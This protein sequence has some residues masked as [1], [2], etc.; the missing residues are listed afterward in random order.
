[1]DPAR[2][3]ITVPDDPSLVDRLAATLAAQGDPPIAMQRSPMAVLA[4]QADT[5]GLMLR[6]RVVQA[7]ENAVGPDWQQVVHS[8][9]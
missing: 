6:S 3:A 1:M 5:A 8:M 9:E 2:F 4:F 7:L